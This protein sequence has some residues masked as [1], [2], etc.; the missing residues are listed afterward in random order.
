[1]HRLSSPGLEL[2]PGSFDTL[3][4]KP[5]SHL[6][7]VLLKAGWQVGQV[8]GLLP[9]ERGW[10]GHTWMNFVPSVCLPLTADTR[11]LLLV[12]IL[13]KR[14]DLGSGSMCAFLEVCLWCACWYG[15]GPT[16]LCMCVCVFGSVCE[17]AHAHISVPEGLCRML[18]G[19]RMW[20]NL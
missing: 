10:Q 17:S 8:A 11:C 16:R 7:L 15:C 13:L 3:L 2:A 6:G 18:V 9:V 4:P 19:T 1:M 5:D 12:Q 20:L 14:S